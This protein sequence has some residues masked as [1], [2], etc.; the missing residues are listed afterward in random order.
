MSAPRGTIQNVTRGH[1]IFFFKKKKKNLRHFFLKKNKNKNKNCTG[2]FGPQ[3]GGRPPPRQNP[4]FLSSRFALRGG[5]ITLVA[6]E[7][8]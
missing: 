7:G 6:H 1:T 3:G 2:G 8:G 5:R 4:I